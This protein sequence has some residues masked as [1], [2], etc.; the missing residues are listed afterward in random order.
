MQNVIFPVNNTADL[1]VILAVIQKFGYQPTVISEIEKQ[2]TA[3][4]QIVNLASLN[5]EQEISED[6]ITSEIKKTR[7]AKKHNATKK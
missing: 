7:K 4:N 5:P 3:R 1:S 6:E 2:M